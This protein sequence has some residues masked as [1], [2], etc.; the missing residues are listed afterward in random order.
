MRLRR[1][2]RGCPCPVAGRSRRPTSRATRCSSASTPFAAP[3]ART[4][5]RAHVAQVFNLRRPRST[6]F[7]P[8]CLSASHRARGYP[9]PAPDARCAH[10]GLRSLDADF[11]PPSMAAL[12]SNAGSRERAAPRSL[13][14]EAQSH[15]GWGRAGSA[16][17]LGSSRSTVGLTR[18]PRD[19]RGFFHGPLK[20]RSGSDGNDS[21]DR[22]ASL[23]AATLDPLAPARGFLAE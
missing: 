11:A 17:S 20:A 6:G 1:A 13:H 22:Q 4:D 7:Q 14:Q 23:A 5:R 16:T 2:A 21:A 9:R 3:G 10:P 8:V 12:V 18:F 15:E 19:P